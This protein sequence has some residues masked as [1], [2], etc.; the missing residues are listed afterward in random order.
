[1]QTHLKLQHFIEHWKDKNEVSMAHQC[2]ARARLAAGDVVGDAKHAV[3]LLMSSG[4]PPLE[5]PVMI[6]EKCKLFFL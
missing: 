1:M 4:L 2:A 6:A 3:L 5:A